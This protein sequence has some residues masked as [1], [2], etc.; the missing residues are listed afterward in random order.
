[1]PTTIKAHTLHDALAQALQSNLVR[2]VNQDGQQWF[3]AADVLRA[4]GVPRRTLADNLR[5]LQDDE[6]RHLRR[7]LV[8][9]NPGVSFGNGGAAFVSLSG[10]WKLALRA[11]SPEARGFQDWVCRTA[12]PQLDAQTDG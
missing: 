6:V 12:L 10:L 8:A 9:P 5:P 3:A 11:D 4:F 2:V 1:M 7:G